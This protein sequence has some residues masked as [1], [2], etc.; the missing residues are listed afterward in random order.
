[1]TART[2][3]TTEERVDV[4]SDDRTANNVVRQEHRELTECEKIDVRVIKDVGAEFLDHL[5]T[6]ASHA[7]D[8]KP[9]RELAIART[10]IE[11]AVMW[12][13]KSITA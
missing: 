9:T 8:R 5:D 7:A 4:T 2:D 12:A 10:K 1:M 13:V 6:I 3:Q 11:E